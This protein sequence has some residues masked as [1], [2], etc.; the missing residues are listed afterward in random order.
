MAMNIKLGLKQSQRLVM[1]TMLQQAIKL[2]PLSKLELVQ[3]IRQELSEN[4]LLDENP[5]IEEDDF[6]QS[7]EKITEKKENEDSE[8]DFNW[9]SYFQN[10][11]NSGFSLSVDSETS[12]PENRIAN[13]VSLSDYLLW[14]LSLSSNDSLERCV[15]AFLIGNIDNDGYLKCDLEEAARHCNVD[16]EFAGNV[17][18]FI[19]SFDPPGIAARNLQECL[20]LQISQLGKNGS[21]AEKLVE[22]HLEKLEER[23]YSRIAKEE[24]VSVD[25]IIAAVKFIRELDP[26]PGLKYNP[27]QIEYIVPDVMVVKVDDDYQVI[28]HNEGI[29]RL[30]INPFY[31]KLLKK[32]NSMQSADKQYIEDK[33][34]SALW[35]I[36][37][38]EQRR[39]T[40]EKVTKSIVK[41]QREFFDKGTSYL[42]PLVLR[43]VA[44][45]I[46]MH[47][48]TV[49]RITTNKYMHTPQGIF[50]LKYF[51]HSGIDSLIGDTASSVTVKERIKKIILNENSKRPYTDQEI[52]ELLRKENVIIARR[53]VTKYRKEMKVLPS[54]RRKKIYNL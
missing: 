53:T 36:K 38:I 26:E 1:T 45:D 18:K 24:G 39:Q 13:E 7:E 47:E 2:L 17:L 4:P 25:D 33:F 48:S 46:E 51:F 23:F 27:K 32:K 3:L 54:S 21:L 11:N 15:G 29:P 31:E 44:E 6:P 37:S 5:T 42:R 10:R 12:S 19:Q 16:I 28:T 41:F 22:N 30:R 8:S 43:D 50:E 34:K 49:S 20:L 40:L 35:L 9:E 52:V 14:Q